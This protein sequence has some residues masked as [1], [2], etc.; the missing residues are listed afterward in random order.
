MNQ[1]SKTFRIL[2]ISLSTRGFGYAV[3]EGENMIVECGKKRIYGDK[4]AGSLAGIEK[5]IARYQ[6]SH[7]VLQ[8]VKAKGARRDKRIKKLHQKV[9]TLA[10]KHKIKAAEIS[11]KELRSTL[12]GNE[13]GTRQEIAELLAKRF[14]DELASRLPQK[15]RAWES[16]DARMDIFD[17]L[18]L[19]VSWKINN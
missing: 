14:P 5:M 7:F 2:A 3:I 1:I 12:L 8:D 11:G 9:V 13:D 16:E 4:N 18:A 10:A 6:P 19:A 17:A 15:R